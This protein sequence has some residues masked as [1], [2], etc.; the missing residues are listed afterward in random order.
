MVWLCACTC[1]TPGA[2]DV[3]PLDL[4]PR[5]SS[6]D[7]GVDRGV[8]LPPQLDAA[9]LVDLPA[10]DFPP[11][12]PCGG[13]RTLKP[14]PITPY[15]GKACGAH[16][17]Q[18][19]FGKWVEID[20]DVRG[21]LLVYPS[22]TN[23]YHLHLLRLDTLKEVRLR[24]YTRP[25]RT[26]TTA[27]TDG[28]HVVYSCLLYSEPVTGGH[29]TMRLAV[30]TVDLT[31][32]QETDLYCRDVPQAQK[33][34]RAG[35]MGLLGETIGLSWNPGVCKNVVYTLPLAGG[36]LS[37]VSSMNASWLSMEG[38]AMV[39]S[40]APSGKVQVVLHMLG[41]GTA[42]KAIRPNSLAQ[43]QP[44]TDGK[45]VVWIEGADCLG[46]VQKDVFHYDIATKKVTQ[47][48]NSSSA[49]FLPDVDG[50]WIVWE[51]WRNTPGGDP[52]INKAN[53]DIYAYNIKTKKE[54]QLTNLPARELT[55]R[56]DNGRVFFQMLDD[57]GAENMFMIDLAAFL[58][59]RSKGHP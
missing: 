41:S 36:T 18:I 26:C 7:R 32:W 43:F 59:A 49:E 16:C 51:D 23:G 2:P 42:P 21:D 56:I 25:A 46:P 17:K 12:P 5:D 53:S 4:V 15:A 27:G 55:P 47:I 14:T 11:L 40:G 57:K 8:D 52:A 48:T 3:A 19:T 22:L 39:W 9:P 10:R 37:Q 45:Q 34:C 24:E 44:R 54:Y 28:T 20:Y 29:P 35:R 31:T 30:S 33:P 6:V 58:A 38:Q 50:D 1:G 13:S